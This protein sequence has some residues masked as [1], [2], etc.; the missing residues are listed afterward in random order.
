MGHRS[1]SN[2][3]FILSVTGQAGE[4]HW[5]REHGPSNKVQPTKSLGFPSLCGDTIF[6]HP[7]LSLNERAKPPQSAKLA[8][9]CRVEA[10]LV[11]ALATETGQSQRGATGSR[12]RAVLRGHRDRGSP[13]ALQARASADRACPRK[14]AACPSGPSRLGVPCT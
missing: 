8:A 6:L 11:V 12:S 2:A 1:P 10:G 9:P 14:R 5:G 4:R 3:V 13:A 7:W